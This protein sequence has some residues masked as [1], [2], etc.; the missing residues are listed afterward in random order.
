[1]IETMNPSVVVRELP[2]RDPVFRVEPSTTLPFVVSPALEASP[3]RQVELQWTVPVIPVASESA[4]QVLSEIVAASKRE[5]DR[6]PTSARAVVN[7]GVALLNAGLLQAA[8]EQ[9]AKAR[10]LDPT[11]IS[12]LAYLARTRLLTN[13]VAAARNLANEIRAIDPS[14]VVWGLLLASV[15]MAEQQPD[16]AAKALKDA[17]AVDPE[18][19][20]PEYLLGL[21]LIASGEGN[22]AIKHLRSAARHHSRSAA[23]HHALGVAFGLGADWRKAIRSL[24]EALVLAPR[25]RE[26][27]LAL[28]NVFGRVQQVDD[29]IGILSSWLTDT[30]HDR[31]AQELLALNYR[32]VGDFRSAR[33][34]LLLALQS[35]PDT[36]LHGDSRAR[37]L[38][39]LGVCV[40]RLGDYEEAAQLYARSIETTPTG[41]AFR[42]LAATYRQLG[43]PDA[44]LR[45]LATAISV[46]PEDADTRL[47]WSVIGAELGHADAS[48][49]M[50]RGLLSTGVAVAEA[51]ACLGSVLSDQKRDYDGAIAVLS[52]G[53][54]RF[55]SDSLIANNLAYVNLMAGNVSDAR[56]LLGRIPPDVVQSSVYLTATYG[57]LHLWEGDVSGAFTLYRSAEDIARQQGHAKLAKIV[58]QK[59][60]LELARAYLRNDDEDSAH[61]HIKKGLAVDGKRSYQDDLRQLRDRLLH[62]ASQP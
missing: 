61:E 32:N 43:N 45:V 39:N 30:P 29:A 4:R 58:R 11:N 8:S 5:A 42:N 33:R 38:N 41:I 17:A 44:A 7:Y 36:E 28:A 26:S 60:H 25:R 55:P 56:Q 46:D 50:L 54:G 12:A 53:H 27:V 51:Y 40:G 10:S 31:E 52:E 3:A 59:M 20:L 21:L 47:L 6:N 24:R 23:V 13:D 62:G 9:L 48:I 15:A 1:M 34:H 18:S 16:V 22:E 37:L 2:V 19:W 35:T 14:S 57:L 49:R